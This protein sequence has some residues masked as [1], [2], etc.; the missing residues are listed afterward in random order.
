MTFIVEIE[1]ETNP[2]KGH[3]QITLGITEGMIEVQAITD[4]GQGQE[5]VKIE[6]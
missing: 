3:S 6:I 4:Q 5:Q 1:V 2:E